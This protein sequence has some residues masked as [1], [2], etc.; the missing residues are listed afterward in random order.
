MRVSEIIRNILD[1]IDQADTEEVVNDIDPNPEG[2]EDNDIKRFRQIVD[3]ADTDEVKGYANTP[4][5]RVAGV[6]AVTHDAGAD[7]WQGTK[8]VDDIRGTTTRI[9]G[10]N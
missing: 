9:H 6:N 10:N 5:E 7:S 1:L 4:K 8:D 2:Y 3:V